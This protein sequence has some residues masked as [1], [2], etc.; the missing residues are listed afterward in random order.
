MLMVRF[1]FLD[2]KSSQTKAKHDKQTDVKKR[3]NSTQLRSLI[4]TSA[5]PAWF[6]FLATSASSRMQC[7]RSL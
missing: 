2:N 5:C 7:C 4:L 6:A 1:S 3:K